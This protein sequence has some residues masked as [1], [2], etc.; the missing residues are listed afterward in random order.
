MDLVCGDKMQKEK[1]R[2]LHRGETRMEMPTGQLIETD[3]LFI[4][5]TTETHTN[6]ATSDP[7]WTERAY[8]CAISKSD[9]FALHW[10]LGKYTNRNVMDGFAGISMGR[11]QRNVRFSRRLEPRP[12]EMAVGPFKYE[13]IEPYESARITLEANEYQPIAAELVQHS[14]QPPWLE[15]RSYVQ[16]AYRRAQDEMRYIV[17]TT[18]SGW[19]EYEGKRIEIDAGSSYGFRDHSWGVKQNSSADAIKFAA[20]PKGIQYRMMWCPALM[21]N[22]KGDTY[23][24]H[25]FF[26]E[27]FS[28]NGNR[29]TDESRVFAPD[30]TCQ[31]ARYTKTHI[32]Y[33]PNTREPL[34]GEVILEMG[35][36]SSRTFNLTIAARSRMCLG[37]GLYHGYKGHHH[38]E[39]RGKLFVE[40]ECL[41]DTS[42]PD[43][44]REVH[45]LRD[46]LVRID[47]PAGGGSGYGILNS[48]VVGAWPEYGLAEEN[49][50]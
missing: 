21:E 49:W 6:V 31:H 5:Q 4:H 1:L 12:L 3:E 17:P 14:L 42:S 29:R 11:Q 48:E 33:D 10:G 24:L 25:I 36:G 44:C 9:D 13:V 41:E 7:A 22:E 15:D 43:T 16:R 50:R 38:G 32:E 27:A 20:M 35:D 34:G 45:Q 18:V 2:T 39:N 28:P 47:D 26:W 37:A 8:G 19:I 23:R 30:G 46:I 40:G